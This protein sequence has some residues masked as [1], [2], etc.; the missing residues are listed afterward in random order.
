LQDFEPT[1]LL[2]PVDK[3]DYNC[4]PYISGQWEALGNRLKEA[5]RVTVFGYS[6]PNTD[7]EAVELLQKAWGN[8]ED[9]AMEEFELIDIQEEAKLLKSWDTFIHTGHYHYC[10]DYFDS[11]LALHPRRTVESYHHWAMPLTPNEIFQ[12]GNKIPNNFK[13]LDELWKWHEPLI[14]AENKF[15]EE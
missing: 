9:R 10:N 1:K 15:N 7:V 4:D 6:A 5:E 2:Y 11:S 3:K 8:V 14:E 12:D 13:T